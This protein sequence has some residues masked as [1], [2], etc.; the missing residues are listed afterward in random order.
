MDFLIEAFKRGGD[1][2]FAE[3]LRDVRPILLPPNPLFSTLTV[4]LKE[5]DAKTIKNVLICMQA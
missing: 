3:V 4:A 2:L 5:G 1:R